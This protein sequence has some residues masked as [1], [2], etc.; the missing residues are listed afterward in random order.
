M[1]IGLPGSP[2]AMISIHSTALRS[3]RTSPGQ[4]V[5]CSTAIAS[6][7]I[8]RGGRPECSGGA[9]HEVAGEHRDVDPPLGQ[10]RHRASARR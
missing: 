4:S 3:W 2:G 5:V 10:R 1:L 8:G 9:Q 6:S 7:L